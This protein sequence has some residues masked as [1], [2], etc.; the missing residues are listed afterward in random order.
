MDNGSLDVHILCK[1]FEEDQIG[2]LEI[3]K[4][5]R[6]HMSCQVTSD[7]KLFFANLAFMCLPIGF[8][9]AASY[10]QDEVLLHALSA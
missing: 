10:T 8:L 4:M 2:L 7:I 3:P 9:S 5:Y 6:V 1:S